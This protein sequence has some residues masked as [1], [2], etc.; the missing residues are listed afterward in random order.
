M[1]GRDD[2]ESIAPGSDVSDDAASWETVE[3]NEM[4]TLENSNEVLFVMQLFCLFYF[5]IQINLNIWNW[6]WFGLE[7]GIRELLF[8]C[9]IIHSHIY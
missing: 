7:V 4:E 8:E 3:D 9:L 6:I 1:V 5:F 2:D